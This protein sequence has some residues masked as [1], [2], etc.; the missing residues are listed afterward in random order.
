[1]MVMIVC[2]IAIIVISVLHISSVLA[3]KV[4][5][6]GIYVKYNIIH[7]NICNKR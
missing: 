3:C 6:M 4:E 1:M 2:G 5:G 7:L